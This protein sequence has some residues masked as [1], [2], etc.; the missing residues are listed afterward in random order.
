[1]RHCE[2]IEG[3]VKSGKRNEAELKI[4][5]ARLIDLEAAINTLKWLR[6]NSDRIKSAL[7]PSLPKA[8]G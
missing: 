8:G 4:K 5:Q 2:I 1:M 6:T 3:L 7:S